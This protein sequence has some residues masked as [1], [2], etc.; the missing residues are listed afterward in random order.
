MLDV[1]SLPAGPV[2]AIAIAGSISILAF[3]AT[4][5]LLGVRRRWREAGWS[6]LVLALAIATMIVH[7]SPG[8][9]VVLT[10]LT[11]A[12]AL[13]NAICLDAAPRWLAVAAI[14]AWIVATVQALLVFH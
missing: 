6:L 12:A 9:H 5:A 4:A 10:S 2:R 13:R 3:A 8:W 14:A 11:L 1:P 7:R